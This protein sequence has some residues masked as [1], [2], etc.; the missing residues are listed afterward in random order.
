VTQHPL[1]LFIPALISLFISMPVKAGDVLPS[2]PGAEGFGAVSTGGRG[3]RV[4]KVTNLNAS[5]P[6]SLQ[7]AC[8]EEGPRIVV[9]EVGGVI[10]GDIRIV[11]SNI[12]IA[13]QTAPLPG[14]TL[15][16]RIFSRYADNVRLH[17][18]VIRHLRIRPPPTTGSNGDAVQLS[19]TERILLDHLSLSWAN[20]EMI[21]ITHSSEVTI[22]WCTIEESDPTGHS[23]GVPHN[24]GILSAYPGSGNISIHHNLFAHHARRL[25]AISPQV[26]GKPADFRNN[27]VYNFRDGLSHEGHKPRAPINIIA[28]YY[29]RGPNAAKVF[30]FNFDPVGQYYVAGNY[31][32]EIGLIDDPRQAKRMF[33]SWF[34]SGR[35]GSVLTSPASAT[36]VNTES[37][38]RAYRLVMDRA[39]AWPRDRVTLRTLNEVLHGKGHWARNAPADPTNDW[40]LDALPHA[41]IGPDSDGDGIPDQWERQHGLNPNDS[42]DHSTIMKD[43]YTAIEHYLNEMAAQ[44]IHVQP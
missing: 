16:G 2:F 39:G 24:Y 35:G 34:Q 44:R 21:D 5:G 1:F 10:H 6:G 42:G 30:P 14:I 32:E 8:A 9:F 13:G 7:A 22:Q 40:F 25:P 11:H 37:A 17:D 29:K 43:G 3:G 4:I 31:F 27:V 19:R 38:E 18:I 15:A 23:K 26:E 41:K 20:D 36:P 12:T 28:N 33:P